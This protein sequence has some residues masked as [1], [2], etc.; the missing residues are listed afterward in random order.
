VITNVTPRSTTPGSNPKGRHLAIWAVAVIAVLLLLKAC[1]FHENTYEKIASEMT[2]ALA[3]NDRAT[4]LK[5]Q[6]AETATHVSR[7]V[8]GRAADKLAPLGKIESVKEVTPKDAAE[9][10]HAFDVKF[11]HGTLHEEIKFD[12]DNKVVAFKYDDPVLK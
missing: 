12:P 9:R 8:V 3:A 10:V 5:F 7:G 1:V 2:A 4:V 11:A 6:N